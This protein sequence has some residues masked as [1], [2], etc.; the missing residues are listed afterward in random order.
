MSVCESSQGSFLLAD[1]KDVLMWKSVCEC[2]WFDH[3][4]NSVLI[5]RGGSQSPE[6]QLSTSWHQISH[7]HS[8]I[9]EDISMDFACGMYRGVGELVRRSG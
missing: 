4:A 7:F 2:F 8:H 5:C 9:N 1:E 6:K 3:V